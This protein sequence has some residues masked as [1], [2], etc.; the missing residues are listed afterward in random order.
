MDTYFLYG[1]NMVVLRESDH[2]RSHLRG[3]FLGTEARFQ[4]EGLIFKEEED[5]NIGIG[6]RVFPKYR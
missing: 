5:C 1:P 6:Q 4:L 2:G 3:P